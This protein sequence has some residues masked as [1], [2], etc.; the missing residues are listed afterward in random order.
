LIATLTGLPYLLAEARPPAGKAFIGAF[1]YPSDY[2]NYLSYAQQAEAGA[3]LLKNKVLLDDHPGGLVNLEWWGIGRL[4]A[5]LGGRLALAYRLFALL[6]AGAFLFVADAWLRRLG[7]PESHRMPALLLVA[8]GGGLGGVLFTLLDWPLP[9]CLDLY[10]GLFPFLGLLAN[11]HFVAGT[12]LLLLALLAFERARDAKGFALAALAGT[13]LALVRPYELLLLV[14]VRA[15]VVALTEPPRRWLGHA[16]PLAG[17]APIVA[18]LYWLFY[19]NPSFAFYAQA[20]Y[21]FPGAKDFAWA[22]GPAVL[23]A[24]VGALRPYEPATRPYRLALLL[25]A[26]AGLVVIVLHPAR[27]SLQILV[28]LGF[29]LLALGSLALV[30]LRPGMAFAVTLAFASSLA[31]AV[32]HVSRPNPLWLTD[33]ATLEVVQALRAACR[34]GDVVMAPPEIGLFAYG[35]TACRALVSHPIAPDH[36]DRLADLGRFGS[37]PPEERRRILDERHIRHLVLP[38]DAGPSPVEWLGPDSAFQR[39]AKVGAWS[40]YSRAAGA[41]PSSL[42]AEPARIP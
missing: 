18:Y 20:P 36:Q 34:P 40:L 35:L 30:R 9:R 24:V 42:H 38:G 26:L 7:L 5:L 16:I 19:L 39:V 29:A 31:A 11:P 33:R 21:G 32:V 25:W 37:G 1:Y 8:T 3:F 12:T 27:F 17:L 41:P 22:L 2:Y 14:I 10:A 13:V 6:A 15:G 28:G 4:S 23:L